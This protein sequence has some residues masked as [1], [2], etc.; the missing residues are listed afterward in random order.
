MGSG[1]ITLVHIVSL[2]E[3]EGFPSSPGSACRLL[4]ADLQQDD[5]PPEASNTHGSELS[6]S[7]TNGP[8]LAG[9]GAESSK[10]PKD[11]AE[12]LRFLHASCTL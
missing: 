2:E 4:Q 9:E 8:G 10:C 6:A 5:R 7:R 1:S 3:E 12:S 11:A